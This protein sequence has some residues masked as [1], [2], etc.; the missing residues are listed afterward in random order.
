MN[1]KPFW[2]SVV[3]RLAFPVR[4]LTPLLK[5]IVMALPQPQ[6]IVRFRLLPLLALCVIA[7][8]SCRHK[9]KTY[10]SDCNIDKNFVKISFKQLMDSIA[11]YDRQY[12]EVSGTYK[13]DKE[14]SALFSDNKGDISGYGLWVNFSQDCPLYLKGTR[15][16]LFEYADG[17]FTQINNKSVTIR[18]LIDVRHHHNRCRASIE[19]VSLVKL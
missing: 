7:F 12:V 1:I 18:G 10:Q 2:G 9:V 14:L 8:S 13:E 4:E 17:Q 11:Q 5:A 19:R 15:Q 3:G 6:Q 16:G